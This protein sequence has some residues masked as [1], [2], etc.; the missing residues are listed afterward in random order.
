MAK[1]LVL[2]SGNVIRN[3]IE[4][5]GGFSPGAG[6]T[7]RLAADFPNA[8]VGDSVVND[9]LVPAGAQIESD[10]QK[11]A[12]IIAQADAIY[13]SQPETVQAAFA[14]LYVAAKD[15]IMRGK[16]GVAREIVLGAQVPANEL[17]SVRDQ[18]ADLLE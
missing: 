8:R 1:Y 16:F 17:N 2:D 5:G 15:A 9:V 13:S 12:R 4:A 6:L 14:P 10:E 7:K 3:L 11:S 18:I